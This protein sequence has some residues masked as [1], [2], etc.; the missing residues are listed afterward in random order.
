[1]DH[2]GQVMDK[3]LISK[4]RNIP[5]YAKGLEQFLDFA[6][7]LASSND[8]IKCPSS[9]CVF[10]QMKTREVVCDHLMRRQF[11]SSYTSWLC[12]GESRMIENKG[13]LNVN[14]DITTEVNFPR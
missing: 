6:F 8:R 12:H 4:L 13:A 3:S 5:E 2:L 9:R 1:M 11:P 14:H 7:L 10:R